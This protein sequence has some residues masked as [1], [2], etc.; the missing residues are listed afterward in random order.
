[1]LSPS[2]EFCGL[3][4]RVVFKWLLFCIVPQIP[5][6]CVLYWH[7][8]GIIKNAYT[9]PRNRRG[10]HVSIIVKAFYKLLLI[11]RFFT[12]CNTQPSIQSNKSLAFRWTFLLS[13]HSISLLN[14]SLCHFFSIHTHLASKCSSQIS[15]RYH[16][17]TNSVHFLRPYEANFP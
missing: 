10:C 3:H 13:P 7:C 15:S 12:N 6:R 16:F 9:L 11:H 2:W 17:L 4:Y 14:Y 5:R 1:M 8:T